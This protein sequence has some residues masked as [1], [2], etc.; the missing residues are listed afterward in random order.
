MRPVFPTPASA[1]EI[2]LRGRDVA[3]FPGLPAGDHAGR[4]A[5]PGVTLQAA[6]HPRGRGSGAMAA[7]FLLVSARRP[8]TRRRT[9]AGAGD[10]YT[11]PGILNSPDRTKCRATVSETWRPPGHDCQ[12]RAVAAM[13]LVRPDAAGPAT[14][15]KSGTHA[16]PVHLIQIIVSQAIACAKSNARLTQVE[17]RPSHQEIT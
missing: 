8:R 10:K 12:D 16:A 9:A 17:M 6:E 11:V 3:F 15:V 13:G 2:A 5:H 4:P 1:S 14:S 7:P